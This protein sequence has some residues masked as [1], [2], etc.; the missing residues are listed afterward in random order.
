MKKNPTKGYAPNF[1][2]LTSIR[3]DIWGFSENMK[4]TPFLIYR[5]LDNVVLL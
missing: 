2:V 3:I 4:L 1:P 5:H